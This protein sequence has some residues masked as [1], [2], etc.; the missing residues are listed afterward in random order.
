LAGRLTLATMY[1]SKLYP[2]PATEKMAEDFIL[3]NL[4]RPLS[5]LIPQV[6]E[7]GAIDDIYHLVRHGI[8]EFDPETKLLTW[9]RRLSRKKMDAFWAR[10]DAENS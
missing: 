7:E 4:A 6:H 1:K 5:G 2:N 10:I 8:V 3:D 9:V